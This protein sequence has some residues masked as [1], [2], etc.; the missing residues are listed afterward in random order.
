MPSGGGGGGREAFTRPLQTLGSNLQL[1]GAVIE[2]VLPSPRFL[3]HLRA[4]LLLHL[5]LVLQICNL[6]ILVFHLPVDNGEKNQAIHTYAWKKI[7]LFTD[8]HRR[9]QGIA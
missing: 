2:V 6:L 5:F 7:C 4:L 9:H 3:E 8:L 1:C